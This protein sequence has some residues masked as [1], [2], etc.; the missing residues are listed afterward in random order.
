MEIFPYIPRILNSI[1]ITHIST[2]FACFHACML[3]IPCSPMT[4]SNFG[5]AKHLQ[6]HAFVKLVVPQLLWI[7]STSFRTLT[8]PRDPTT[9][10]FL[11][12]RVS[13]TQRCL[14]KLFYQPKV[15]LASYFQIFTPNLCGLW[16]Q[17]WTCLK[18]VIEHEIP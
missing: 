10:I 16:W 4:L 13:V 5:L 17:G 9:L 18:T 6:A 3:H 8:I 12:L 1:D 14:V 2:G 7:S 11:Q 15:F